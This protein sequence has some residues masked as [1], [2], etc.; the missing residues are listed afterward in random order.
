MLLTHDDDFLFLQL[1]MISLD[2][3]ALPRIYISLTLLCG[4]VLV[5]VK[6]KELLC[7]VVLQHDFFKLS[8]NVCFVVPDLPA[9]QLAVEVKQPAVVHECIT[10]YM[11]VVWLL[12]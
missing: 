7:S 3:L 12:R 6:N 1:H 11:E 10:P 2:S 9:Y 8:T 5:L 4:K